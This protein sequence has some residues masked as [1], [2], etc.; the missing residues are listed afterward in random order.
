MKPILIFGGTTE[1][2]QLAQQLPALGYSVTVSVATPYGAEML[3]G[4]N[5]QVLTGRLTAD[6]MAQL[7]NSGGYGSVIDATHPY[8][9]EVSQN[10]RA[11]AAQTGVS[12]ERLLRPAGREEEQSISVSSPQE[13]ALRLCALPGNILLTTGSK[14]LD[15]FTAIPHYQQRVWV[16]ILASEESLH[17]ALS[18]G[19]SPKHIVA[20]HGPCS[21][22][23]NI[24]LL[25]QFDISLM[26]SKRSGAEGGFPEKVAAA[27]AA[28]VQ[29]VVIERP[30][31]EEGF[32][33]QTLVEAYRR[34]CSL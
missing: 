4:L 33:V 11:A 18:L 28:G 1:G 26:V 34:R 5:V 16:R 9:A 19:Y 30:V 2:V 17:R 20:M 7:I 31:Q 13:A 27:K 14:D 22:E 12:Y 23:L 21:T 24:A 3:H 10:I 32:T 6:G 8:A 25:R 29:L 15:V